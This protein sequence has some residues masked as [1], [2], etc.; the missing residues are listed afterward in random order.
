MSIKK[1]FKTLSLMICFSILLLSAKVYSEEI[2]LQA[3]DFF[4]I[5]FNPEL[6]EHNGFITLDSNNNNDPLIYSNLALEETIS[7]SLNEPAPMPLSVLVSAN[8]LVLE[9]VD[10]EGEAFT[11]TSKN[12]DV[13]HNDLLTPNLFIFTSGMDN[14]P[15][16]QLIRS[17]GENITFSDGEDPDIYIAPPQGFQVIFSS[18]TAPTPT[19]PSFDGNSGGNPDAGPLNDDPIYDTP[20]PSANGCSLSSSTHSNISPAL[21]LGMSLFAFVMGLMKKSFL[22][23]L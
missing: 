9:P 23:R 21:L 14:S 17:G 2:K 12:G 1:T 15:T 4:F 5:K 13:N 16:I 7:I 6:V 3:G 18:E 11:V 19:P 10:I 8:T 22:K 20:E